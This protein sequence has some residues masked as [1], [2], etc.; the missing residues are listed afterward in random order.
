VNYFGHD[1][2]A[3]YNFSGDV[4]DISG[5]GR[6][7][8]VNGPL[9]SLDRE[10][11]ESGALSFEDNFQYVAFPNGVSLHGQSE[12]TIAIIAK[13]NQAP[14]NNILYYEST[15]TPTASR[16]VLSVLPNGQIALS[17]RDY[18]LD[19]SV[20]KLS[21]QTPSVVPFGEWTDIAVV[22]DAVNQK[23]MFYV[24]NNLVFSVTVAI[25]NLGSSDAS[26]IRVG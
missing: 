13:L 23:Q 6:D 26:I 17:W 11:V 22:W 4:I 25:S 19:S 2:W 5:I 16:I 9:P 7:G 10:N 3:R 1:L 18:L 24:N 15:S 21:I 12:F 14:N 8:V 20:K